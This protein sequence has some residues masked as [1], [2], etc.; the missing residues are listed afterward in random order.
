MLPSVTSNPTLQV[1]KVA[2]IEVYLLFISF[3][4]NTMILKP[5][6]KKMLFGIA[7]FGFSDPG[8]REGGGF[9]KIRT[10]LN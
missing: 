1:K 4:S 2:D 3:E 7:A 5:S 8:G 10:F 6:F 9:F